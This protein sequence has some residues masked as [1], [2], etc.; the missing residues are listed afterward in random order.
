MDLPSLMALLHTRAGALP[1]ETEIQGK[2]GFGELRC[3]AGSLLRGGQCWGAACGSQG[4]RCPNPRGRAVLMGSPGCS[5]YRA[6]LVS[7]KEEQAHRDGGFNTL[8]RAPITHPALLYSFPLETSGG[9]H[10]HHRTV[11]QSCANT[12]EIFSVCS[13][14]GN[15]GKPT[16]LHRSQ[17]SPLFPSPQPH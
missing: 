11:L 14:E 2:L 17:L 4:S 3:T 8:S 7:G 1:A 16:L 13:A 10:H 6:W 15:G 5:A 12:P 9:S